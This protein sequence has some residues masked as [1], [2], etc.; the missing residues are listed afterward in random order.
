MDID[1]F[2]LYLHGH[3]TLSKCITD[4]K[5]D[6]V[7]WSLMDTGFRACCWTAYWYRVIVN[8]DTYDEYKHVSRLL[9]APIRVQEE[10]SS[11]MYIWKRRAVLYRL[12]FVLLS[13]DVHPFHLFAET[14]FYVVPYCYR[15][16]CLYSSIFVSIGTLLYMFVFNINILRSFTLA[17]LFFWSWQT[18]SSGH[19]CT[20]IQRRYMLCVK[21]STGRSAHCCRIC[22]LLL[23]VNR[24]T[25]QHSLHHAC[26]HL[27][28]IWVEHISSRFLFEHVLS[29]FGS[30]MA[31][32]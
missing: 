28:S 15:I 9:A 30:S 10:A 32:R 20:C 12:G 3:I 24:I 5:W 11:D 17:D 13:C 1:N 23:Y 26:L 18:L 21:I 22:C 27:S 14:L 31:G 2:N 8:T 25:L 16:F 7:H 4:A 6:S 19:L 29:M